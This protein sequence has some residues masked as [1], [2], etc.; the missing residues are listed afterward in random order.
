MRKYTQH[1][2]L[3]VFFYCLAI[4]S[5]QAQTQVLVNTTVVPPYSPYIS[6]YVD[7]P[8]KV[9]LTLVNQ[10]NTEQRIKLWVRIAGDNGVSATT[11]SDFAPSA[12]VILPPFGTFTADFTKDETRG[13]FDPHHVT[14]TGITQA[15]LIQNQALPEGNYTICVK[16]LDYT[17]GQPLSMDGL[18][19]T[20]PFGIY[21]IDAPQPIQPFCGSN[22]QLGNP[23]NIVFSWT[24]PATAPGTI[25]YEF[26]LKQVPNTLNPADVIKNAAFPVLYNTT[27]NATNV[28][29]YTNAYPALE[30]GKKYVWRVKAIDPFTTIQFKNGGFSEPC[31][32]V[33]DNGPIT[34]TR[35]D[36]LPSG[37][38]PIELR[39]PTN[40]ATV[41]IAKTSSTTGEA[42][43]YTF[44]WKRP[45][46]ISGVAFTG[47]V[48]RIA[49]VKAGQTTAQAFAVDTQVKS[50]YVPAYNIAGLSSSTLTYQYKNLGDFKPG[51]KYAWDVH[52]SGSGSAAYNKYYSE[53]WN[54]QVKK[55]YGQY[56][57]S[58]HLNYSYH[59]PKESTFVWNGTGIT[60]IIPGSGPTSAKGGSY[61]YANKKINFYK[62]L[63]VTEGNSNVVTFDGTAYMMFEKAVNGKATFADIGDW[64][65][66][67]TT[68]GLGYFEFKT[69]AVLGEIMDT[70][71]GGTTY[72]YKKGLKISV[73][74]DGYGI[75]TFDN[76]YVNNPDGY[77]MVDEQKNVSKDFYARV[78]S[79]NLDV[80][81]KELPKKSYY[82]KTQPVEPQP[83]KVTIYVLRK[84]KYPQIYSPKHECGND[85]EN[86][87]QIGGKQYAVV[88]RLETSTNVTAHFKDLV[89]NDEQNPAVDKFYVYAKY[90]EGLEEIMTPVEY[91][92]SDFVSCA[93]GNI[94]QTFQSSSDYE[95]FY[96]AGCFDRKITIIPDLLVNTSISGI[97]KGHWNCNTK[98]GDDPNVKTDK[99][100]ANTTIMLV[101]EYVYQN[102]NGTETIAKNLPANLTKT[103]D[104]GIFD[105]ATTDGAGQFKFNLNVYSDSSKIATKLGKVGTYNGKDI[106][107]VLRINVLND[108]YYS[109]DNSFVVDGGY[110]YDIGTVSAN[111]REARLQG[112]VTKVWTN[113]DKWVGLNG[114]RVYLCR[115]K[116]K[117][118]T[119]PADEGNSN[120][121]SYP[122]VKDVDGTDY[123][124]VAETNTDKDG[125]FTFTRLAAL[126]SG[127]NSVYDDPYYV[128][129]LPDELGMNNYST[130]YPYE[131]GL[132]KCLSCYPLTYNS[133]QPA[134]APEMTNLYIEATALAPRIRGTLHPASNMAFTALQDA[135]VMLFTIPDKSAYN[136]AVYDK[137]TFG[138]QDVSDV[139]A[140]YGV[141]FF[142]A[143][144][145]YKLYKTFTTGADGKFDFQNLPDKKIWFLWVQKAGFLD[146]VYLVRG[147][148]PLLKGQ[149]E[150]VFLDLR[151]P[152][153]VKVK[154]VE[155]GTTTAVKAKII[156]GQGYSWSQTQTKNCSYSSVTTPGPYGTTGYVAENCEEEATLLVPYGKVKLY[157]YPENMSLYRADSV[158]VDIKSTT[159]V[160]NTIEVKRK[161]HEIDFY[162]YSSDEEHYISYSWVRLNNAN[163][164]NEKKRNAV[165]GSGPAPLVLKNQ[166]PYLEFES[167][168]TKY[169][170]IVYGSDDKRSYVP[171]YVTVT[172]DA[173]KDDYTYVEVALDPG[174]TLKG[175]V[176]SGGKPVAGAKV[177][178][179]PQHTTIP[180][181]ATTDADGKYEL[182]GIPMK[183]NIVIHAVKSPSNY[184]GDNYT[185]S[186][187]PS[188]SSG[189]SYYYNQSAGP[190]GN[191]FI[192]SGNNW[193]G[194]YGLG[195]IGGSS[196]NSG[197]SGGITLSGNAAGNPFSGGNGFY[198]YNG[199][200]SANQGN[201]QAW[202][203]EDTY[204]HDFELIE[205]NF[206]LSS[207][208]GFPV[209]VTGMKNGSNGSQKVTGRLVN[210]PS[211]GVVRVASDAT[212]PFADVEVKAATDKGP[213]GKPFM[214]PVS[215]PVWT[216]CFGIPTT[217]YNKTISSL[218]TPDFFSGLLIGKSGNKGVIKGMLMLQGNTFTTGIQ[219]NQSQMLLAPA[220]NPSD[221]V[222]EAITSDKS[223]PSYGSTGFKVFGYANG[224]R[225]PIKFNLYSRYPNTES[226]KDSTLLLNDQLYLR[227]IL[228]T[229]IQ[230]VDGG[231]DINLRTGLITASVN[232][233]SSISNS[234]TP[235]TLALGQWSLS[236]N[237]WSLS[238]EGGLVLKTGAINTGISVPFTNMSVTEK[239]LLF[240][241]YQVNNLKLGGI[242]DINV[243]PKSVVSFGY[244]NST[245]G[246]CWSMVVLPPQ[247]ASVC[248]SF[249]PLEG[250]TS[251]STF[252]I[253]SIRSFSK[254][255]NN[256]IMLVN[257]ATP[258]EIYKVAT[259]QA[260]ALDAGKDYVQLGGSID[261]HVPQ[262]VY[263][264]NFGLKYM[265][266]GS[267]KVVP[268]FDNP[269]E[270]K[271]KTKGI[272][273]TFPATT[274]TYVFKDNLLQLKGELKDQ[275][276]AASNYK[277]DVQLTKTSTD[278]KLEAIGT[279][280]RFYYE[281]GGTRYITN[282]KGAMGKSGAGWNNFA[283][284]GDLAGM[285]EG[286]QGDHKKVF[287][288]IKGDI[289]ADPGNQIGVKNVETPLGNMSFVYDVHRKAMIG[290]AH[291]E[292]ALGVQQVTMDMELLLGRDQWY[293]FGTGNI[294]Y[295][296][297]FLFKE[298]KGAMWLGYTKS[299][300]SPTIISSFK[301]FSLDGNSL[302]ANISGS[303][304]I[305]IINA[306]S[307][308]MPV[309]K[310]PQIDLNLGGIVE[311]GLDHEI[312]LNIINAFKYDGLASS[313]GFLA[314]GYVYLHAYAGASVVVG[315]VHASVEVKE[316]VEIAG[317]ISKD[318]ISVATTAGTG[319]CLGGSAEIGGGCCDADCDGHWYCP[320][321]STGVS[322]HCWIH[323]G[324][325]YENSI[326]PSGLGNFDFRVKDPS[327]GKGGCE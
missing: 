310:I 262:L 178:V 305:G 266:D 35:P 185:G 119:I 306:G 57:V 84:T 53:V 143:F 235:I 294:K 215:L 277:F 147:G 47:Y 280:N 140:M 246:G 96:N 1:V 210:I 154:L 231:G 146:Q 194:N 133:Q 148:A 149:Q 95:K 288:T 179:D 157:I 177:Y 63:L 245:F 282:I 134:S 150:S 182:K 7:Q 64:V 109:P 200:V 166:V 226:D 114:L 31:F 183:D 102:P 323:F 201:L 296:P 248:S 203:G 289:V 269:G 159:K 291:I 195:G 261:F 241:E 10:T 21:Y 153:E 199:G 247:G 198:D 196:N 94:D 90:T 290:T 65:G 117:R 4:V 105:I 219:F 11:R 165:V 268:T 82:N 236:A 78:K 237:K 320:C 184:I 73:A 307:V 163:L 190:I 51:V 224:G 8:N 271:L 5:L 205:S 254:G 171:K 255:S 318:H 176:L 129:V 113:Q 192:P 77:A 292:S 212:I 293:V 321:I 118:K 97:L 28:L 324:A 36:T 322:A 33:T 213:S 240:G 204:S 144:A 128:M 137:G 15:A 298:T 276:P 124:V 301:S 108:Y 38:A 141:N 22:L 243:V 88:G 257:D 299:G 167:T 250:M 32:F 122:S 50:I 168:A 127:K 66:S 191:N 135:K 311:A 69:G 87:L 89:V 197:N 145:N 164:K 316:Q 286:V 256:K 58:G 45:A 319:M 111:V 24:P 239:D 37:N 302:P 56:T 233:I 126:E 20:A 79:F 230:H 169:D 13:Y 272:S 270:F 62:A 223:L 267:G 216:G 100:L 251:G 278:Y 232:D 283:F 115:G 156:V 175:R 188:N 40:N 211:N 83:K 44:E 106:Y 67:T 19:C 29:V 9:L 225:A 123:D 101:G 151:L 75:T 81:F 125:Y 281:T 42:D 52:G 120:T 162:V 313:I 186:F 93:I 27:I 263:Q 30:P 103:N 2:L 326:P 287:M 234:T 23:Q 325:S 12:P 130:P 303:E 85:N 295:P 273:A 43:H 244:D 242:I 189:G 308:K 264:T 187:K 39:T 18:G 139:Y 220:N 104:W 16:A 48:L 170:F 17:T 25:Q 110:D 238:K 160:L 173:E 206:D 249:G 228:H 258:V 99:P 284:N 202:L 54:F 131:I 209:E 207:F 315:C 208:L 72:H 274:G 253:S 300:F 152:V 181:E 221:A 161:R 193:T 92:T 158:L 304:Y 317:S 112:R 132:N 279:A 172:S 55:N 70:T 227:P 98:Q 217:L 155:E 107:R 68:D 74:E 312:G 76:P 60:P 275:D 327:C 86:V 46:S 91:R 218:L 6:T 297:D 229:N 180:I 59:L 41:D 121:V 80:I 259:F 61:P 260:S 222:F 26:T 14:L 71:V 314:G 49:E 309:P 214:N 3:S 174:A 265:K 142:T 252:K 138:V 34:D 116:N 136:D 285:D